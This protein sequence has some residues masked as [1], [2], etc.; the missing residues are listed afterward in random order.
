MVAPINRDLNNN[1]LTIQ[2]K[3]NSKKSKSCW[4]TNQKYTITGTICGL[5]GV[6]LMGAGIYLMQQ[7][8]TTTAITNSAKLAGG[9]LLTATG[10]TGMM[11]PPALVCF[12]Y[13]SHAQ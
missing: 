9:M 10:A 4:T 1:I 2:L 11:I 7:A 12:K 13:L 8:I 6:I 5:A 3:S